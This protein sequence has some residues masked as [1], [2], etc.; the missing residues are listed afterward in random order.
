MAPADRTKAAASG[1]QH[2][3]QELQRQAAELERELDGLGRTRENLQQSFDA[4][5]LKTLSDAVKAVEKEM[6]GIEVR[7]AQLVFEKKRAADIVARNTEEIRSL[8]QEAAS[9]AAQLEE[10]RPVARADPP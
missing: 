5:D 10:A 6:S 9:A 3:I 7:I 8:E 2:Q 1:R 4:I